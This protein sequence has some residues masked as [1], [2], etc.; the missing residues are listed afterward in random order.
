MLIRRGS[1]S[2]GTVWLTDQPRQARDLQQTAPVIGIVGPGSE[3]ELWSGVSYLAE[4]AEAVTDS[5]AERVWCRYYGQ[6]LVLARGDGWRLRE[7]KESDL[8]G[9]KR[10]YRDPEAERF[11]ECPVEREDAKEKD[12]T[13]WLQAY[14]K[15]VYAMDEP[16]MWTLADSRDR[17]LGRFGLEWRREGE[18][19][20]YYLGYGLLPEARG[21]GYIDKCAKVFLPTLEDQWGIERIYLTCKKENQASIRC[22]KRLGFR[23]WG[24]QDQDCLLFVMSVSI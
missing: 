16:A 1:D 8:E 12:W 3:Y 18:C 5:Y 17:F 9:M 11:L 21:K 24:R 4:T 7:M 6:A 20:G 19:S 15:E 13:D 14:R 2:F 10:L 22:A 23:E